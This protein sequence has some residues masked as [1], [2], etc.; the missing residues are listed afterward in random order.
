LGDKSF[1]PDVEHLAW[2]ESTLAAVRGGDTTEATSALLALAFDEPDRKWIEGI[3]L[4]LVDG[5]QDWQV[6]AL[7]VICMG[8]V[9][10][11][12]GEISPAVKLKLEELL[13]DQLLASRAQNAL[14]DIEVFANGQ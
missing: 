2:R 5:S 9:A 8:H 14:D 4:D 6:R 12:H 3:L 13:A 1:R 10:R 7:A 11:I